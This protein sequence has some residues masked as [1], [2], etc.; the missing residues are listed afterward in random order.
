MT[1]PQF[2]ELA[3]YWTKNPPTHL[4][5]RSMVG[6]GRETRTESLADLMAR[7]GPGGVLRA[8]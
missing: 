6:F 5:L 7:I 2:Q 4:L 8:S 1:L 3:A